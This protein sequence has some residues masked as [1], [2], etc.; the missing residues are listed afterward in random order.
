MRHQGILNKHPRHQHD[1]GV[2]TL[3]KLNDDCIRFCS[4]INNPSKR[5]AQGGFGEE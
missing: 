4:T 1:E 5:Q 2:Q 3:D